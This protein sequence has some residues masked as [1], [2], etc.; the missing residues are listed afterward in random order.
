M[1]VGAVVVCDGLFCWV[2]GVLSCG[3]PA[4]FCD[5]LAHSSVANPLNVPHNFHY[6]VDKKYKAIPNGP[7]EL[8]TVMKISDRV[9]RILGSLYTFRYFFQ[10]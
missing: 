10:L 8:N 4:T 7:R 5:L 3:W 2:V 1:F 6:L 9:H